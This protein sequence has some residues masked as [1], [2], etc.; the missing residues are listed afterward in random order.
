MAHIVARVYPHIRPIP[1]L[2]SSYAAHPLRR[3]WNEGYICNSEI[4]DIEKYKENVK[5]KSHPV[6]HFYGHYAS[7][8]H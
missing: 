2:P 4:S 8:G 7:D 3:R 1:I 6:A 5:R